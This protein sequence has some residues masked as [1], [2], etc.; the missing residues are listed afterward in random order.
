MSW[1][2]NQKLTQTFT[3]SDFSEAI[4]FVNNVANIANEQN[5][6]PGI[7]VHDFNKVTIETITHDENAITQK[8]H[9]LA[10]AIDALSMIG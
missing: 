6:H 2:Q 9:D 10:A 4:E 1:Q 5:H 8:D 7:K 3:F